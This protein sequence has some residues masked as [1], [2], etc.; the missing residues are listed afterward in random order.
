MKASIEDVARRA[1]VST[2]TVSRTFSKPHLVSE[3]TRRKVQEAAD[4]LGFFVSRSAAILKSGRMYRVALLFGGTQIDWFTAR[5]IEGL[6]SVLRDAGYDLVVYP[7]GDDEARQAFFDDLPV[8]GNADAVIVSSFDV[9]E[10]QRQRLE[11]AKVPLVGINSNSPAFSASVGIDD[12]QAVTTAMHYLM[13]LGHRNIAYVYEKFSNSLQYSSHARIDAFERICGQTPG[14]QGTIYDIDPGV[15]VRGAVIG[16]LVNAAERP[17]A[18]LCHQ[19]SI[20]IPFFFTMQQNG[21]R[22]PGDISVMGFD[23]SQFAAD[24]GLTTIRQDPVASAAEA[25]RLTIDLIEGRPPED[26]HLMSPTS[27]VIRSSTVAPAG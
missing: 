1:G 18:L 24:V 27:L 4:E 5:I 14:M 8:R 15:E 10:R 23:D 13:N 2:A 3:H 9:G 12:S 20:A 22:I 25:A 11:Q 26:P 16:A 17:T 21:L 6:N 7:I 19:D